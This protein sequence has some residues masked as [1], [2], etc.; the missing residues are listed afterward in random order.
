[1]EFIDSVHN[2]KTTYG[3]LEINHGQPFFKRTIGKN[4]I[5]ELALYHGNSLEVRCE[6]GTLSLCIDAYDHDC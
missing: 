5:N 4:A 1:M 3:T 6:H 2:I